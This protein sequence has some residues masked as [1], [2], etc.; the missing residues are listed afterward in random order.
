MGIRHNFKNGASNDNEFFFKKD[1]ILVSGADLGTFVSQETSAKFKVIEVDGDK[2]LEIET[3]INEETTT[4]KISIEE[5]I[6]KT[7]NAA[8][9]FHKHQQILEKLSKINPSLRLILSS[10]VDIARSYYNFDPSYLNRDEYS[11]NINL[12]YSDLDLTTFYG[13][14]TLLKILPNNRYSFKHLD[15]ELD[16]ESFN[17]EIAR[18]TKVGQQRQELIDLCKEN[19]GEKIIINKSSNQEDKYVFFPEVFIKSDNGLNIVI[20]NDNV[21]IKDSENNIIESRT[22]DSYI[23][24]LQ[25]PSQSISPARIESTESTISRS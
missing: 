12:I 3:K 16:E 9:T 11:S 10:N 5:F 6:S 7:K 8:L 21:L 19:Y 2:S 25:K 22:I 15:Q 20:K 1:P 14:S 18:L 13:R 24:D 17:E 4:L 23:S